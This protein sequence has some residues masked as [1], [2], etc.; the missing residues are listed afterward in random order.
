MG[1]GLSGRAGAQPFDI[2]ERPA[3][4]RVDGSVGSCRTR[5]FSPCEDLRQNPLRF[6][7]VQGDW[8]WE[9]RVICHD[10]PQGRA[11]DVQYGQDLL[12]NN[13][14]VRQVETVRIGGGVGRYGYRMVHSVESV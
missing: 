4:D 8:L 11:R 12:P 7:R 13:K 10:S 9:C 14:S 2:F 3:T 1:L 5:A 6:R